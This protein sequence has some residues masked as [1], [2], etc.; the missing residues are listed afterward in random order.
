[1]NFDQLLNATLANVD[2]KLTNQQAAQLVADHRNGHLQENFAASNPNRDAAIGLVRKA[3]VTLQEQTDGG[4]PVLVNPNRDQFATG[5]QELTVG[6]YGDESV[7]EGVR[8]STEAYF[9]QQRSMKTLQAERDNLLTQAQALQ[10]TDPQGAQRMTERAKQVDAD[11]RQAQLDM[12]AT[13][14]QLTEQAHGNE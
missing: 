13:R 10:N 7:P 4:N 2:T 6:T 8:V 5:Q 1:M 3:Y 9:E 14:K 12:S 11:I